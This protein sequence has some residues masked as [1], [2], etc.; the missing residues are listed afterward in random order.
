MM[1]RIK[2]YLQ[3]RCSYWRKW[4][5]LILLNYMRSIKLIKLSILLLKCVKEANYS[6]WL[7]RRNLWLKRKLQSSCDRYSQLLLI[8]I[9]I[10][11]AIGIS[12]LKISSWKK[13]RIS[14]VLS[15]LILESPKFLNKNNFKISLK[16]QPCTSHLRLLEGNTENKLTIGK[17]LI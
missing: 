17:T 11:Y 14:G 13:R 3:V 9:N 12:N 8:C 2:I 6:I 5:I 10:M 16:E 7:S 4:I 15:S 1:L